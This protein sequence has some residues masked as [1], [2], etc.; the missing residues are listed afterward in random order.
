MN[1][2]SRAI[3]AQ[4][5]PDSNSYNA[6]RKHWSDLISS[7]HGHELK[8]M[9]HLLYLA[10]I[11]RDWRKGFTPPTN[12][13]KLENGAFEGWIMFRALQAIHLKFKQDELL[14]PFGG[15]ITPAMLETLRKHLPTANTYSF[16][17]IDFT[18]TTFPF[19]AYLENQENSN[20]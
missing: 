20:G 5:F 11:G 6:L 14:L 8:A 7:K 1:T 4:F 16:K 15:L 9:H 19:D 17:P 13:R 18:N 3:T 10:F 12:Q 2:L